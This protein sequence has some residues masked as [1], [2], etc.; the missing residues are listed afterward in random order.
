MSGCLWGLL[1]GA[2]LN[3]ITHDAVRAPGR[4]LSE[5]FQRLGNMTG[6]TTA[7]VC[8]VVGR[9]SS[10][11][12]LPGGKLLL[13]WMATGYHAAILFDKDD[14]FERITHESSS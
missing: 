9:P 11:S 2:V 13:Q 7:E 14:V 8:A 4:A 12:A 1:G 5:R 6:K 10:V 3:G